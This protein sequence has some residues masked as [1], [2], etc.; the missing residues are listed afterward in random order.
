MGNP[1][2]RAGVKHEH[3]LRMRAVAGSCGAP[4]E[5]RHSFQQPLKTAVPMKTTISA[6]FL[7]PTLSALLFVC[8]G[9][10]TLAAGEIFREYTYKYGATPDTH[11]TELDPNTRRDFS[12]QQKWAAAL[13]RHVPRPLVLDLTGATR[14]ELTVEYWGG[15]IGTSGQ[16]FQV[17][18]NGWT[19]LPQPQGTP[20][21]P[22]R[23][24]RTLLGNNAVPIPLNW[25]RHGTNVVQFAAGR[26]IA[27]SF[28][29]GLYWLY[30]FTVRVYYDE[31]RPHPAGELV[32][33]KSADHFGDV[34]ELE[35]C[36]SPESTPVRRVEFIGEYEDFDWDG[37]GVWREWQFT[38]H[39]GVLSNHLGTAHAAPWRA[40]FDA[41]WLTDQ[42]QPVRVRARVTDTAGMTSLTPPVEIKQRRTSRNV[43]L[44]KPALVPESFS[45]RNGK[46]SRE[47][48]LDVPEAALKKARSVRL[49]ASTWSANVD[50]DSIHE[51]RLNGERLADRPGIFH[52]YAFVTLEVPT[53]RL[54]SGTNV[55]TLYSTFKGHAFE[56]NWPGPVLLVEFQQ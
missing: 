45:S 34:L 4:W 33:P 49:V 47:C 6:R 8:A 35:F 50:D 5:A 51:L 11:Y 41:R 26:Q 16:Q 38:T 18:S 25:L 44:I 36:A 14:A 12:K 56:V 7:A 43:K 20:A 17:N 53:G 2:D 31:T 21:E 55:I 30:D 1:A 37:D 28:D 42:A 3:L 46:L 27:Y 32:T 19:D 24:Y 52:N 54:R 39:H 23:F 29:F 9:Y 13:P 22:Q 15:H 40:T 48:I 10:R